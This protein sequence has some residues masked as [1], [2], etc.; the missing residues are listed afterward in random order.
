MRR[1]RGNVPVTASPP[2]AGGPA[3]QYPP[4]WL[5]WRRCAATSSSTRTLMGRRPD[6]MLPDCRLLGLRE[7]I[8]ATVGHDL[9]V[10]WAVEDDH[11]VEQHQVVEAL[12]PSRTIV[13]DDAGVPG[14]SRSQV[15]PWR[16]VTRVMAAPS[17]SCNGWSGSVVAELSSSLPSRATNHGV[18]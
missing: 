12:V 3:T 11:R 10:C 18:P 2:A 8:D 15:C 4:G 1:D 6:G 17:T 7:R 9:Q 14:S 5:R 13:T 16:S